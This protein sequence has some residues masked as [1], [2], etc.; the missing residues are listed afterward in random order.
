MYV[1][2]SHTLAASLRLST[3]MR[4]DH[5]P[6]NEGSLVAAT[7]QKPAK[8]E[9]SR[10]HVSILSDARSAVERA[11]GRFVQFLPNTARDGFGTRRSGC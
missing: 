2:D 6:S 4:A 9:Q 1:R 5:L 7:D 10:P 3:K 11:A 8:G